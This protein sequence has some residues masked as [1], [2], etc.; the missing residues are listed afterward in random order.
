MGVVQSLI[1]EGYPPETKF[2][3]ANIPDLTGKVMIVTGA[4]SGAYISTTIA[5]SQLALCLH[6]LGLC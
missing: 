2:T 4:N 5:L 1:N 6:R 3:P